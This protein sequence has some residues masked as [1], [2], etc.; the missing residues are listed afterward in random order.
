MG[1]RTA[2]VLQLHLRAEPSVTSCEEFNLNDYINLNAWKNISDKLE[3]LAFTPHF[4]SWQHFV[5]MCACVK[6]KDRP[7][8]LHCVHF[9]TQHQIK[10]VVEHYSKQI[11]NKTFSDLSVTARLAQTLI[12]QQI[13]IL[14]CGGFPT[15]NNQFDCYTLNTHCTVYWASNMQHREACS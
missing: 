4:V 6:Q 8:S 2:R 13:I 3:T 9:H 5:S 15:D 12:W 10:K 11:V 1:H 7:E 14:F